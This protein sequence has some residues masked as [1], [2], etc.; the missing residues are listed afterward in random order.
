MCFSSLTK[1]TYR[2][3]RNFFM[4][5][6]EKQSNGTNPLKLKVAQLKLMGDMLFH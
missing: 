1:I 6:S 2:R 5:L 4:F 3:V